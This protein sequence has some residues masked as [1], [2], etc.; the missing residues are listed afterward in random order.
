ME[1][2]YIDCFKNIKFKYR[3]AL[4]KNWRYDKKGGG[5]Y[6]KESQEVLDFIKEIYPND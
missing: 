3:F 6:T 5:Y 1:D 4:T 2:C